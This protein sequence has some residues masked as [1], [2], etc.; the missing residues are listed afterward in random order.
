MKEKLYKA[1]AIFEIVVALGA[2]SSP[3]CSTEWIEWS[4]KA[5]SKLFTAANVAV[6]IGFV[7]DATG[8]FCAKG[9]EA[10]ADAT[11]NGAAHLHKI[12]REE[13][14]HHLDGYAEDNA[15]GVAV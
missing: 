15:E 2:E 1:L 7:A 13:E 14:R 10:V 4:L 9:V 5:L 6:L 3:R 12:E 11:E 8:C